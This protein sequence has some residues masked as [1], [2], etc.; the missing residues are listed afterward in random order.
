MYFIIFFNM[1]QQ[2]LSKYWNCEQNHLL[3]WLPNKLNLYYSASHNIKSNTTCTLMVENKK[4]TKSIL[5]YKMSKNLNFEK[6]TD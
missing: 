2:K 3:P 1:Q 6:Q 5:W 4:L